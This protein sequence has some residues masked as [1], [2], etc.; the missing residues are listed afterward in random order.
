VPRLARHL[1][2]LLL[3]PCA[4]IAAQADAAPARDIGAGFVVRL[5]AG[6]FPERAA[7]LAAARAAIAARAGDPP[8]AERLRELAARRAAG[9]AEAITA[10]GGTV[11]AVLCAPH[12]LHATLPAAAVDAVRAHRDVAALEPVRSVRA[13]TGDATGPANHAATQVHATLG[14][15]G[16]GQVLALVDTGVEL[17]YLGSGQPHPAFVD[18]QGQSRVVRS[19]SVQ[20]TSLADR[21]DQNGH[22]T[23]TGAVAAGARWSGSPLVADG[24][25][26]RALL[27]TYRVTFGAGDIALDVDLARAYGEILLD[28][29]G[30][31]PIRVANCSFSGNPDPRAVEQAALDELA[32]FGDVL[33]V[34]SAGNVPLPQNHDFRATEQSQA[35]SNGLAVGAVAKSTHAIAPFSATGP[36][37]GQGARTFPDLCAVGQAVR[38]AQRTSLAVATVDGTSYAAPMVAGTALLVRQARPDLDAAATKAILCAT[39]TDLGASNPGRDRNA[40]GLGLLRSDLAVAA[41]L[42]AAGPQAP[43]TGEV[44]PFRLFR[45][46]IG[47]GGEQTFDVALPAGATIRAALVW[48]RTDATAAGDADLDLEVTTAA[49]TRLA[50]GNATRNLYEQVVF[51]TGAAGA[52]RLHVRGVAVPGDDAG[53]ALALA[54][55]GSAGATPAIVRIPASCQGTGRDL[56]AQ[57][58]LPAGQGFGGARTN[59]PLADVPLLL[60]VAY[61]AA[62]VPGPR[63]VRALAFR[64]AEHEGPT[65]AL[66]VDLRV[67]VGYTALPPNGLS[68]LPGANFLPVPPPQVVFAGTATLPPTLPEPTADEFDFVLPLPAPF[69]LDPLHGNVLVQIE[70]LGNGNNGQAMPIGLDAR[71]VSTGPSLGAL[72]QFAGSPF[73]L[74]IPQQPAIAFVADAP[75]GAGLRLHWDRPLRAGGTMRF[76]LASAREGALA[77]RLVGLGDRWLGVALPAPLLSLGAP[78]CALAAPP[79]DVAAAAVD[80][81]G[82]MLHTLGAPAAP[83]L[84]GTRARVQFLVLDAA[85]NALGVV[86]SDGVDLLIGGP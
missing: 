4:P 49:G 10:A 66:A 59:K 20:G 58:V 14:L 16:E 9:V 53:F 44:G 6:A 31:L 56:G 55:A 26:P 79:D 71:A 62:Q 73:A 25:A 42:A 28:A 40:F 5:G 68:P 69:P 13:Q 82:Q 43:G 7:L 47:A 46:S 72:L 83:A 37:H 50:L 75:R 48:L 22:G 51:G 70:V 81:A 80:A 84:T 85:A 36:L 67:T 38:T 15:R 41:A 34:T 77:L 39:A 86:T 27:A 65:P 23:G 29:I 17:S 2:L 61:A 11:H 60:Q 12:A 76:A 64:R 54:D 18:A 8:L 52:C 33:V 19:W 74:A 30:G 57:L 45:G 78:G 1:P 24:F 21:S 35:A 32:L 3:C 63:T